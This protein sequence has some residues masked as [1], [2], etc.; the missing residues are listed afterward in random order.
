MSQY[1]IELMAMLKYCRPELQ[2]DELENEAQKVYNNIKNAL[3]ENRERVNS[4]K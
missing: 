3:D 2:G 4:K 1:I